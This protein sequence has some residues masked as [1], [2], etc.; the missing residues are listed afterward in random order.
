MNQIFFI[1][2]CPRS[3]T[4]F[5]AGL[6]AGHGVWVGDCIEADQHNQMGYYENKQIVQI[7]KDLLK[8]NG[9]KARSDTHPIYIHNNVL[10]YQ[11]NI[12]KEV[13]KVVGRQKAWLYKDSKILLTPSYWVSQFP[14][15]IWILPYRDQDKIIDSLMRHDVWARRLRKSKR[16]EHYF[17]MMVARLRHSQDCIE[18]IA[19]NTITVETDSLI[20]DREKAKEFIEKLGLVWDPEAYDKFVKP[21]LWHG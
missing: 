3:G 9:M 14:E 19:K 11:P 17:D 8:G 15:A 2:G 21:K 1:A 10:S 20:S 18:L 5:I 7:T 12:R 4:S 6:L 13:L 16:P